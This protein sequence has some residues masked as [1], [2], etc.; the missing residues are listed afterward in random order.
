MRMYSQP[1]MSRNSTAW[2]S[3]PSSVHTCSRARLRGAK[4]DRV[5]GVQ[6]S[7]EWLV[8][9]VQNP[10]GGSAGT[11]SGVPVRRA[12]VVIGRDWRTTTS[13]SAV[14]A[15]STSWG[16]PSTRSAR[17]ARSA[18]VAAVPASITPTASGDRRCGASRTSHRSGVTAPETSRSPTPWAASTTT[19]P[20][21]PVT[22][23]AVKATPAATAA[24]I[25]CTSTAT[26]G[27][28][29]GPA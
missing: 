18:T 3:S 12:R 16:R 8:S 1:P 21:S 19:T 20:R 2:N 22:G 25:G 11:G 14:T 28:G 24:T 5:N 9:R 27:A 4:T 26:A 7:G 29:P 6:G 13:P 15:H 10:A 23:S 17:R